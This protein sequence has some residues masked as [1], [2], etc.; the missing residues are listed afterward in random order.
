[1]YFGFLPC[2]TLNFLAW[3]ASMSIPLS[4]IKADTTLKYLAVGYLLYLKCD[5]SLE[6]T[7]VS[8][9]PVSIILLALLAT[10]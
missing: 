9:P 6:R 1:M 3:D 7:L 4:K 2:L 10:D 5:I 8:L